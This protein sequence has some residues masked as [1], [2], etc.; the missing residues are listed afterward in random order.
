MAL[1]YGK[2]ASSPVLARD[3][4]MLRPNDRYV[5]NRDRLFTEAVAAVKDGTEQV[6][7]DRPDLEMA[8]KPLFEKMVQ[9]AQDMVAKGKLFPHDAVVSTEFARILTGGEIEPGTKWSEQDLLDAERRAFLTLAKTSATQ[10]RIV[11]LM[12]HGKSIRN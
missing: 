11:G 1:G 3:M 12:D 10:E 5:N 4:A 9:W 7:F 6:P 8:G 2:T